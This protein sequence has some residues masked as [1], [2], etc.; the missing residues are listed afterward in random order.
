M[1]F[2]SKIGQESTYLDYKTILN[3]PELNSWIENPEFT[4]IC[5]TIYQA[6]ID[7]LVRPNNACSPFVFGKMY[8]SGALSIK[9]LWEDIDYEKLKLTFFALAKKMID[10]EYVVQ[11]SEVK[12]ISEEEESQIIY[13]KP[14]YRL[15]KIDDKANQLLGNIHL[16]LR[17]KGN[18]LV[19]LKV[20]VHRYNDR[21]WHAGH[22]FDTF[23]GFI[24]NSTP[25][26]LY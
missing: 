15:P 19:F 22:D 26:D 13:L 17:S 2:I 11:L 12:I 24:F 6:Y 25:V 9:E 20:I 14:S 7:Y 4:G 16:E 8:S 1:K 10:N 23:M 18:Q 21:K 5:K 3:S